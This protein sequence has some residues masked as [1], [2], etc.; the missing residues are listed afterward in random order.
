MPVKKLFILAI[1]TVFS[2][3]NP[4]HAG[5]V[6]QIATLNYPPYQYVEN[7]QIKGFTADIV[8]EIFKRMDQPIQIKR[9]PFQRAIHNIKNGKADIIF[10]FYYKKEREAFADYSKE[11]LVD[12]TIALFVRND[13]SI[14]FDG[15]LSKLNQYRFGLVRFS[16]GKIFDSAVKNNV[17]TKLDYVSEMDL[18][19]KKFLA[20]RFEIL[21]SDR[22]VAHYYYTKVIANSRGVK[23]KELKPP[24]DTFPAFIG[25]SK[26][27]NLDAI[28]KKVDDTLKKMKS[29]GTYQEIIDAHAQ[30]WGIS[31]HADQ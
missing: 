29:D 5:R 28:R 17:I 26:V 16:Y 18:N 10:T 11:T 30:T 27:N 22:W 1:I 2:T 14:E 4:C 20:K 24:V 15:N 7:G 12:Q 21:P 25:F 9:Y 3:I 31:L 23:I 13:S 6:L 8:R 19:M